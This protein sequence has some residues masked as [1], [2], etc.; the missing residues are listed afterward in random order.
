MHISE[1]HISGFL[2]PLP[3]GNM[4]TTIPGSSGYFRQ[5]CSASDMLLSDG[6]SLLEARKKRKTV[7]RS[8]IFSLSR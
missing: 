2:P 4:A 3:C 8:Y 5:I 7:F 6:A 1:W